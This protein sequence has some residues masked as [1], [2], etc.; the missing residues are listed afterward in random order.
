MKIVFMSRGWIDYR[1]WA[2]TDTKTL[3]K[4]NELIEQCRRDPFAGTAK[5]ES[6]RGSL[7]GW[8]SRRINATDRLVYRVSGKGDE[9]Q[10]EIASCRFHYD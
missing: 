6:L 5:P 10:L 8:W 9:Q 3:R 2:D 4:V 7:K 1:H